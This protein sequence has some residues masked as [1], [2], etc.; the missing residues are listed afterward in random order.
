V[1]GLLPRDSGASPK[2]GVYVGS[3]LEPVETIAVRSL[4]RP[5]PHFFAVELR[6]DLVRRSVTKDRF[7]F[8]SAGRARFSNP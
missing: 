6:A 5:F 4:S 7:E 3:I 8:V 1:L 2:T